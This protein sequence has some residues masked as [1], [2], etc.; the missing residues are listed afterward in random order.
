MPSAVEW[1]GAGAEWRRSST[2]TV[3]RGRT[4]RL[5]ADAVVVACGALNSTK[6]LFDSACPDFP[7]GLGNTE[8]LLG[9]FLHDHP[10]EWWSVRDD[11]PAVPAGARQLPDPSPVRGR[12]R[13]SGHV[14]DDRATPRRGRRSLSFTPLKTA[15]FGVQV[16][17]TMVPTPEEPCAPEPRSS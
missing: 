16:F 14:V 3:D 2:T 9:Q 11:P 12:R 10:R 5:A 8:G 4:E 15:V 1:S 7:D 13:R 6:L 17:G